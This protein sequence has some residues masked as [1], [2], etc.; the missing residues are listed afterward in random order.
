MP[1]LALFQLAMLKSWE[2]ARD[3]LTCSYMALYTYSHITFSI[4]DTGYYE[5]V[6]GVLVKNIQHFGP[7][8]AR[9][10]NKKSE[11]AELKKTTII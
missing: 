10:T 5:V 7:V 8:Y 4:P 6:K 2:W 3:D 9:Y 11:V 1:L